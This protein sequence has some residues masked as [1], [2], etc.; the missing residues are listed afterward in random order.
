MISLPEEKDAEIMTPY[1]DYSV[2]E[3]KEAYKKL[4]FLSDL[5][6]ADLAEMEH[7]LA[8]LREKDPLP[9][10]RSV[11]E[12]WE[13]FQS[14]Y[15]KE[16]ADIGIRNY[17]ESE[18]VSAEE[19][20]LE[21]V[22]AAPSEETAAPARPKRRRKLVRI[23]LLAAALVALMAAI[24]ATAAAMGYNLWGWLPVWGK[25]DVRFV[26]ETPAQE[27]DEDDLQDIPMVLASLGI[28]E[29]LYPTWLPEDFSRVET[30]T[31]L[32]PVFLH[33]SYKGNDRELTITI[34]PTSGS[35]SAIYQKNDQ[36]PEEYVAGNVV[37]YI[38]NNSGELSTTWYT[39]NYT[40]LLVGNV[41]LEEM[42]FIVNSVY[43]VKK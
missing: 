36:H 1:E 35:E 37:H 32:D 24:T 18:E 10:T 34:S 40:V 30:I 26:S 21:K 25:E 22:S 6:D 8:I 20:V 39:E 11:D 43:E 2:D 28:T 3:L 27:P 5:N 7:I 38:F 4:F 16:P 33:E 13:E 41:S 29:P 42:E 9:P 31:S 23:A 12:L 15:M 14:V 17:A 19:P